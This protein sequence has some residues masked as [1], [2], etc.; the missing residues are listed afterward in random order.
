MTK[1]KLK[2]GDK[3][4]HSEIREGKAELLVDN[5]LAS[6]FVAEDES[7]HRWMINYNDVNYKI[8]AQN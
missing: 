2:E 6:Q 8:V 4:T 3:I 5:L 1:N 7:G